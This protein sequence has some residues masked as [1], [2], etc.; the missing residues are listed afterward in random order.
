M[1]PRRSAF[2]LIELLVVIAVIAILVGL[3]LPALASARTAARSAK[4]LSNL[5][6]LGIAWSTYMNDFDNF[7]IGQGTNYQ[8]KIRWSFGGVHWYDIDA[9]GNPV[10]PGVSA[11]FLSGV[12]P[13]NPYVASD[14]VQSARAEIFKCPV[15]A[16]CV[17][18][19][20]REPVIWQSFGSGNRSE[21]G[22]FTVF[23]Q[24][25]TSYQANSW[26]YCDVRAAWFGA[27]TGS[28]RPSNGPRHVVV[29]PSKLI[30]LSDAGASAA[31]RY[32]KAERDMLGGG[33]IVEG[34]WHGYEVG[35]HVFMDGSA[36]REIEMNAI[37]KS[38]YTFY[39]DPDRNV[40]SR[41][42]QPE[43]PN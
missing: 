36:R 18:S 2:T 19:K 40:P 31:G 33:G 11:S 17:Y 6:Q 27:P 21:E 25:G 23:G 29:S 3:L 9:A 37:T 39:L 32:T 10:N 28:Y 16:G 35:Q 4:C 41:S 22:R 26:L 8:A 38:S 5:R 14:L 42:R 15:D 20:S 30:V 24:L 7:P 12:R 13:L 1:Q 34:W 43:A